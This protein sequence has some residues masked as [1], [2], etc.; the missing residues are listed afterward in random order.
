MVREKY[1][2]TR[3]S[4]RT[5]ATTTTRAA[6]PHVMFHKPKSASGSDMAKEYK[7]KFIEIT[8]Q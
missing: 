8:K 7:I 1:R 6:Q 2:L 3:G 5:R 4:R